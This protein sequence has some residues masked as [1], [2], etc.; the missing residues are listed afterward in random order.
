MFAG[1][2]QRQRTPQAT[3]ETTPPSAALRFTDQ[4]T[5]LVLTP[6]L[7]T[8]THVLDPCLSLYVSLSA[9]SPQVYQSPL[10]TASVNSLCWAPYE[11]GL[12]LAAAS[13]DGALSVLTYQPDGSWHADKMEGAHPIGCTAV[14]WSPAAPKGSLVASQAPGQPVRRLASAGC[15]NCVRV[16]T[17]GEQARQWRQEGPPLAAHTGALVPAGITASEQLL[18]AAGSASRPA[19]ADFR[20][21]TMLDLAVPA[22]L[23]YA[24]CHR[25]G[26]GC[27]LGPQFWA[28][29]EHNRQCGPG[30]QGCHLDRAD[31]RWVGRTA[32]QL[33]QGRVCVTCCSCWHLARLRA[34]LEPCLAASS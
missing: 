16:W 31:G 6:S 27:C 25:L 8:L 22:R 7:F 11:L 20:G 1:W 29:H 4:H 24:S 26:A 21:I 18:S 13:S 3:W 34:R 12:A 30:W 9:L 17:Y 28:A 5:S 14:S 32:I 2:E 23:P 10:H 33:A 19:V 15:D